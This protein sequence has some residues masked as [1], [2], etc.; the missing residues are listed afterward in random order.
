MPTF[1]WNIDP[2][3]IGLVGG[4]V[5]DRSNGGLIVIPIL[6]AS[7]AIALAAAGGAFMS[8]RAGDRGS[9][10]SRLVFA[11][12]FAAIGVLSQ[13]W[14]FWWGIRYYSLIFVIVF[15][16]GYWL[17][18]WQVKRGGGG[19]ETAGDFIT[20][21][22]VAVLVGARLGHVIFYDLDKA[23]EDPLWVFAV[24][25][26]GL[27][28]HGATVGLIIAMW[29]F[30]KRK[31]T[32]F[33]DAA[34]R[35]SFSV[36]LGA[37]LVRAGNFLNSEIVGRRTDG[38]WG[39]RFTRTCVERPNG[40]R[41]CWGYD[42]ALRH[43]SQLYEIGLGLLV[44]AALIVADRAWGKEKRPRGALTFLLIAIYFMGRF[45]VEFWKEFQ[46]NETWE[47]TITMGQLLSLPGIV[48]GA[49]GLWWSFS[50]RLP[51]GWGKDVRRTR[52]EEDEEQENTADED[53]TEERR[54][55]DEDEENDRDVDDE[56]R[57]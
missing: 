16:G 44:L 45:I 40:D 13:S 54:T 7:L 56:Q 30:V 22:V 27:A 31:R 8:Y 53:A 21:G 43:P 37:T 39:V 55:Q 9:A 33:L 6:Y 26:G 35:F 28:S 3:F 10:I 25:T 20:Y 5:A 49:Y 38:T 23:L 51:A 1:S 24:W 15:L 41:D 52:R 29:I 47:E 46:V 36:G 57:P 12:V 48:L 2:V 34:D 18:H 14:A 19:A 4:A 42:D 11:A 50:K 32:S 17:L